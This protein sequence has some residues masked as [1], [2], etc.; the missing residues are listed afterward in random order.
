[1]VNEPSV[2]DTIAILRGLK[3]R[4]EVHHGVRIQDAALIAAATLSHR[5]ISDRFLPDKA[6]DLVDEAASR[7]KIELDSLPTEIDQ[8]ERQIM[9][10]EME[11]QALKKEKDA[12]SKERLAKLEK[13]LADLKEHS[14]RLKAQWQKEKEE[15]GKSQKIAEQIEQLKTELEQA[16]RRGELHRASEI[17]YGLIPELQKQLDSLKEKQ[18]GGGHALLKE[19]V[20]EEDIAKVVSSWTGIPVSR[21]QES[22]RQKLVRMEERLMER[23]VGQEQAIKAVSNAVRRARAG[24]QDENRPIGSFM[25]LGP[26]GV[27]KTELS[28]ALAEFLF[29]DERAMIRLDMSEYMEKHTVARLIGAPPGYVGYEE[30]GQLSEAV[31]RKPYSVVLFDEVEKAHHDVF[32]VLLQVL[33]DGRITDGQGR[34]VD[35]K[36]TVIILTSNIG[37]QYIMEDLSK[38][39]RNRRVTEALRA[40][41]RPEFLNRIDEIIIFDRLDDRQITKIVDIQL[42]RLVER[43]ENNGI[44]VELTDDAKRFLAKEGY[45][46]A[47]GARPLKRV[48]QREI[49]D[50]LSLEILDGKF[51]DGDRIKVDAD[52]NRLVFN[53]V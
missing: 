33:D 32:N 2:E 27:G 37:S 41:F 22:E 17:Q 52:E 38:E 49:L 30:G 46:P 51:H 15:I 47:Y 21:L 48:I 19:E 50:P 13:E 29:D 43:L 4:Y 1:M 35:F 26:T 12:A 18:A 14:D 9:Q 42:K 16:Q 40:H 10:L 7:L 45:D 25:F 53:N 24:L 39:E 3:E 34:T 20:T 5:Y 36:N 8:L 44:S 28:K 11:K 31:R 23:V 6:V